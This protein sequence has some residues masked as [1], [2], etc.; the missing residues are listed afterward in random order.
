MCVFVCSLFSVSLTRLYHS[1]LAESNSQVA[2]LRGMLLHFDGERE[3]AEQKLERMQEW[4]HS[5]TFR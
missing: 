2:G 5:K 4:M 3:R 1:E